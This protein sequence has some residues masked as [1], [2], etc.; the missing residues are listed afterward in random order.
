MLTAA[1][2]GALTEESV[3]DGLVVAAG[4]P[5]EDCEEEGLEDDFDPDNV[6]RTAAD[7]GRVLA[8]DGDGVEEADTVEA[9]LGE[10]ATVS[11]GEVIAA[12]GGEVATL[13]LPVR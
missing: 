3:A 8:R 7:F 2:A 9:E 5:A 1:K 4:L 6:W 11:G 12:E 10:T 13:V